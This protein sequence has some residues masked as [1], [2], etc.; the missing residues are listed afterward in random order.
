MGG[1]DARRARVL[2]V[3]DELQQQ[4]DPID[5]ATFEEQLWENCRRYYQ[6]CAVL[7]GALV[8]LNRM[9]TDTPPRLT[10]THDHST[11][12]TAPT[13]PRFTHLPIRC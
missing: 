5:W 12:T 2:S 10:H 6:R 7:Y 9:H 1:V 3:I 11:I 13:A 4:L 8:Q